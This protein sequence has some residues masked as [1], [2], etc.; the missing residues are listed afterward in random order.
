MLDKVLKNET[1][2]GTLIQGKNR[3]PMRKFK[4]IVKTD[5]EE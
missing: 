3:K 5:L 4:K 1:Y 2:I